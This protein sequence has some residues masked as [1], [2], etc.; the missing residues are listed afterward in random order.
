[1]TELT[2]AVYEFFYASIF[3]GS[4][5]LF[6]DRPANMQIHLLNAT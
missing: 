2:S 1:M 5:I 6:G 3:S 4:V